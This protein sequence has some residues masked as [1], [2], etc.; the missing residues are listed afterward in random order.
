MQI[1]M[2]RTFPVP[3]STGWQYL[4]NIAEIPHWR[5]GVIEILDPEA[6]W[7]EPGDSYRFVTRVLVRRAEGTSTLEELREGEFERFTA[8]MPGLPAVHEEWHFAPAGEGAFTL[9]VVQE[10]EPATGL[11]GKAFDGM[12]LP[13]AAERDLRRELDNLEDVFALHPAE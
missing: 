6:A 7:S 8:R 13:R 1:G 10:T 4:Q 2:T 3:L 5:I 12:L 11:F 9:K